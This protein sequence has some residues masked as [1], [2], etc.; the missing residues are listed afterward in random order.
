MLIIYN[1]VD[2]TRSPRAGEEDGRDY[3]FVKREVM[4]REIA[5]HKFIEHAAFSGNL[6]GTS[7]AAVD[8]VTQSGKICIL[9]IE[10]NGVQSVK[11]TNMNARFVFIQPP[12]LEVLEKRL[13]ARGTET[14]ESL[15]K[16]LAEVEADLTLAQR[17]GFYDLII[18][19][20]DLETAY[21]TFKNF[22]ATQY[23]LG[24]N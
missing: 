13:R 22:V 19:N 2:T 24:K 15:K 9:D 14:E 12:S 8:A 23:E 11:K 3:H 5:D 7:F 18:I 20:D 6:Y 21:S 10:R 4:E 16:R 1:D 17:P